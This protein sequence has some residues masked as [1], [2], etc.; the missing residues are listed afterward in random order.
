MKHIVNILKISTRKLRKSYEWCVCTLFICQ[1]RIHLYWRWR[2]R[3]FANV[4]RIT[5]RTGQPSWFSDGSG[6]HKR[7]RRRWDMASCQ[8]SLNSV[9]QLQR[10][11]RKCLRQSET[12]AANLFF[13]AARKTKLGRGRRDLASCQ[14]SLNA[15][16]RF[17]R[18][19]KCFSHSEAGA[20]ILFFIPKNINLVE[21]VKNASCQVLLNFVQRCQRISWKCEKLTT[22]DG[23]T[24]GRRTIHDCNS[25]CGPSTQVR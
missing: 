25:A 17:Q 10:S 1:P 8:V 11:R 24:D 21:D 19:R 23:R 16:P 18:S 2:G 14:V 20:G 15:V 12:R 4:R 5:G 3:R 22:T 7:G 13:R 6:K 9:Q